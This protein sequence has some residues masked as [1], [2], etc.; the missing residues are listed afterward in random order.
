MKN[1]VWN[2]VNDVND[3]LPVLQQKL[4]FKMFSPAGIDGACVGN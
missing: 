1:Y 3:V 2:H 4:F